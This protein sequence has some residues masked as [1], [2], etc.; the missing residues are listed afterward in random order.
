ML[1]CLLLWP[2]LRLEAW[3]LSWMGGRCLGNNLHRVWHPRLMCS[4]C[5]VYQ[6]CSLVF[7]SILQI[8]CSATLRVESQLLLTE[9]DWHLCAQLL[10]LPALRL[11]RT[12]GTNNCYFCL[13]GVLLSYF[14]LVLYNYLMSPVPVRPAHCQ[15]CTISI[16]ANACLRWTLACSKFTACEKQAFCS[17]RIFSSCGLWCWMHGLCCCWGLW[18]WRCLPPCLGLRWAHSCAQ[19]LRPSPVY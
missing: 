5:P 10:C 19:R 4:L 8:F 9:S 18:Q 3:I 15:S 12:A 14:L 16:L 6:I 11:G 17:S 7:F 13:Q 1:S 2:L